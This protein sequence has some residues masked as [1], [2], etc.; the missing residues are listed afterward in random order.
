MI[1]VDWDEVDPG[2]HVW[3]SF[4]DKQPCVVVGPNRLRDLQGNEFDHRGVILIQP[5]FVIDKG[6]MIWGMTKRRYEELK[7]KRDM[8]NI[9]LKNYGR[10]FGAVYLFLGEIPNDHSES[11]EAEPLRSIAEAGFS[12]CCGS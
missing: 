10:L 8:P 7:A 6:A 3:M 2:D 5:Y 4:H 1:Q 9:D 11:Q 12:G